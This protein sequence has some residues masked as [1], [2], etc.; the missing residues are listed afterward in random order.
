MPRWVWGDVWCAAANDRT[1]GKS[2]EIALT[3]IVISVQAGLVYHILTGEGEMLTL[4]YRISDICYPAV[5][6]H[7]CAWFKVRLTGVEGN[8]FGWGQGERC[9]DCGQLPSKWVWKKHDFKTSSLSSW[10]WLRLF[11]KHFI[12]FF[13][14]QPHFHAFLRFVSTKTGRF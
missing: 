14:P 2:I 3:I 9:R 5:E 1:I 6:C 7:L 11:K 8:D 4:N 10:I 12:N 13:T